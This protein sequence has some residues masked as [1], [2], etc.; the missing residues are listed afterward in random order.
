MTTHASLQPH[1]HNHDIAKDF[2]TPPPHQ[3]RR[4]L[5]RMSLLFFWSAFACIDSRPTITF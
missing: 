1:M 2:I 5:R 4:S 3:G